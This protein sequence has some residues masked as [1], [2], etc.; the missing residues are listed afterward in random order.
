MN[1]QRMMD[2]ITAVFGVFMTFF[3][4]GVGLYIALIVRLNMDNFLKYLVGFT[5]TFY[6]IY[7]GI[8]TYQKIR[9]SFFRKESDENVD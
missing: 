2:Q 9:D 8:R 5:F 1:Q 3:Y 4:I 7:R 6:G